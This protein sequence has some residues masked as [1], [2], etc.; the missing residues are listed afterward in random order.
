MNARL[1]VSLQSP[2]AGVYR[3][4]RCVRE[5]HIYHGINRTNPRAEIVVELMVAQQVQL[6]GFPAAGG[7]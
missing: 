3:N 4:D 2:T 6:P 1:L 5:R 7:L